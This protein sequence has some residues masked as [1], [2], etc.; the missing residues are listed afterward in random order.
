[1]GYNKTEK[2]LGTNFDD[3]SSLQISRK[4]VHVIL[5]NQEF[6]KIIIIMK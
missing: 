2:I 4:L 6:L 3:L 5:N 1:M